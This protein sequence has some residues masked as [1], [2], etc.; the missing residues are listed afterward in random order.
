MSVQCQLCKKEFKAEAGLK[1]HM[2]REHKK[3]N[4]KATTKAE[5]EKGM[6]VDGVNLIPGTNFLKAFQGPG[7]ENGIYI[8]SKSCDKPSVFD[9]IAAVKAAART[10]GGTKELVEMA[11]AMDK[12]GI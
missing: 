12:A 11:N 9:Q 5:A 7:T 6:T 1:I 4:V 3:G 2:G 8:V 10:C